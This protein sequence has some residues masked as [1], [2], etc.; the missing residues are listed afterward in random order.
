MIIMKRKIKWIIYNI[1]DICLDNKEED[2]ESKN[3]ISNYE[4]NS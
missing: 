4:S 1:E 2:N 3:T